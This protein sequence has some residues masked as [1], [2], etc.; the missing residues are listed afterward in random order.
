MFKLNLP[1]F[2]H[3]IRQQEGKLMIFDSIRK[4]YVVLTPEEWVRQHFVNFLLSEKRYPRS[5]ISVERGLTYNDMPRRSDIVLHDRSARPWLLVECKSP[6]VKIN[7]D[8]FRQ[9]AVYNTRLGA[10]YLAVTNGMV[11]IFCEVDRQAGSVRY[12]EG[13]PDFEDK[14]PPSIA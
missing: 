8:T 10:R 4:K 6:Q 5:L 7:Q 14:S 1:S 11:H 13:L 12:I 3:R 2:E 9:I